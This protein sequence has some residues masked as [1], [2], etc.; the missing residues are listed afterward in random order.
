GRFVIFKSLYQ[1]IEKEQPDYIF[2]HAATTPSLLSVNKYK[3]KH[4]NTVVVV[5]NHADLQIS[6]RNKLWKLFYYNI[7]W[8]LVNKIVKNNVDKYFG[9]TP[10]RCVF[11]NKEL[12]IPNEK[13]ELLPIGADTEKVK[14]TK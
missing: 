7:F 12:K 13:I 2:H 8:T 9:V 5:D 3:K 11:L 10:A 1:M 6:A 4:P 14:R